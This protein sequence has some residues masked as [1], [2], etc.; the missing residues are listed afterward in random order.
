[1]G[2]DS[3]F[4]QQLFLFT[5]I[6]LSLTKQQTYRTVSMMWMTPFDAGMSGMMT[7]AEP[8]DDCMVII[9]PFLKSKYQ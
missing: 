3:M 4:S 5:C 1:M 8:L 2:E 9:L 6:V 7:L